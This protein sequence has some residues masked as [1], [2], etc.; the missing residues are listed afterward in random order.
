MP[1]IWRNYYALIHKQIEQVFNDILSGSGCLSKLA[2]ARTSRPI[3]ATFL[4]WNRGTQYGLKK[5]KETKEKKNMAEYF[6]VSSL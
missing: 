4:P 3:N 5:K 6:C 1:V 2:P